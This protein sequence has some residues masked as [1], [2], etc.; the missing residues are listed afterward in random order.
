MS[1]PAV[2][3]LP[4]HLTSQ[5]QALP[6]IFLQR[7]SAGAASEP[8]SEPPA[9]EAGPLR[10]LRVLQQAER[11]GSGAAAPPE[12]QPARVGICDQQAIGV[13]TSVGGA[14]DHREV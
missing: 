1:R 14:D 13:D 5:T 10:L 2:F 3:W 4:N 11:R 12:P 6:P 9:P 7:S 8:A